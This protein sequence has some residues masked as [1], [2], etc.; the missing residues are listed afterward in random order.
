MFAVC[1]KRRAGALFSRFS[2]VRWAWLGFSRQVFAGKNR[3]QSQAL[4]DREEEE[5][6]DCETNS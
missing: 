4:R 3:R 5:G 6:G 2:D 1:W